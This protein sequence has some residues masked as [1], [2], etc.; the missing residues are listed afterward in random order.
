MVCLATPVRAEEE[1]P[2]DFPVASWLGSPDRRDFPWRVELSHPWLTFQ[3]RHAVRTEVTIRVRDLLAAG[4]SLTD[5]HFMVKVADQD[6]RWL[7]GQS[8]SHF[9]PPRE[10]SAAHRIRSFTGLLL[11]PGRYTIALMVYD[12]AHHRGNISRLAVEVTPLKQD[13]LPDMEH[14]LPRLQFLERDQMVAYQR[15]SFATVDPYALGDGDLRLP[16]RNAGPIVVDIVANLSLSVT[17][18]SPASE[19]P[20]FF[21]QW[22]GGKL[23]QISNVLSQIDLQAG[24]IRISALDVRRQRIFLDRRD[25]AH[26]DWSQ[27][28]EQVTGMRRATIDVGTLAADKQQPAFLARF[29]ESLSAGPSCVQEPAGRVLILVSDALVFPNGTRMTAVLPERMPEV[30][31]YYLSLV[32]VAG[33]RWD[34]IHNVLKPL[35]PWHFSSPIRGTSASPWRS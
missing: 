16:V 18:D 11:R 10:I 20:D 6:G 8:Y 5:L 3:Q 21:Y 32:P 27:W 30:R 9:E 24:C 26:L 34:E 22:N 7:P 35:H 29:L 25:A 4:L 17:T 33:G 28:K 15:M 14:D 19:A 1:L 12:T 13:P 31:A 2:A 23:L